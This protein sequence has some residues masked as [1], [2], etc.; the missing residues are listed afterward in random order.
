MPLYVYKC[1][2][3]GHEFE[4]LIAYIARDDQKSCPKC[5]KVSKRV[6]ATM[7]G[8]SV[9]ADRNATLVSPKEIDKAVGADA[10][11]RWNWLETRKNKRWAGRKPQEI[12]VPRNKDGSYKPVEALGDPSTKKLRKEYS[13]ALAE[14]RAERMKKGINQFDGPG[15]IA[16][17][18]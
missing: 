3:C 5:G 16:D 17:D 4:D 9:K 15:A 18:A 14:H 7:F 10:D 11:K 6:E 1:A 13:E 8:V 2:E 12:E